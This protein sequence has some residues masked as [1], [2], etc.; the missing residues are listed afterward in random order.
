MAL[1]YA[2]VAKRYNDENLYFSVIDGNRAF[3]KIRLEQQ[4]NVESLGINS[5]LEYVQQ[6][7][8]NDDVFFITLHG[9]IEGVRG[10][11]TRSRGRRKD[12]NSNCLILI[13]KIVY[14]KYA[15]CFKLYFL[16]L[17]SEHRYSIEIAGRSP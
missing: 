10:W 15:I 2:R 8:I 9:Q 1:S 6:S 5:I 13:K 3:F 7:D 17:E 16:A 12:K 11:S 14:I 4:L